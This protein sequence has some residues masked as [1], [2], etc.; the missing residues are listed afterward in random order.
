MLLMD[1]EDTL[2]RYKS[3]PLCHEDTTVISVFVQDGGCT[4]PGDVAKA[5]C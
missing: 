1:L 4:C 5:F 3:L 2:S